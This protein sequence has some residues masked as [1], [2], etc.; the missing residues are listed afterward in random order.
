MVEMEEDAER[1]RRETSSLHAQAL[2]HHQQT[3]DQVCG[4][5]TVCGYA[6]SRL[7]GGERNLAPLWHYAEG[8][9]SVEF[10]VE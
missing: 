6:H 2:V 8:S 3:L 9:D 5:F 1:L 7:I 10:N 4:W